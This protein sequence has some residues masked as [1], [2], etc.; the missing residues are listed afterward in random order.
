M[1]QRLVSAINEVKGKEDILAELLPMFSIGDSPASISTV[2]G[3]AEA[4]AL[5]AFDVL[6]EPD[7]DK[8]IEAFSKT[9]VLK[10]RTPQVRLVTVSTKILRAKN[11]H[12]SNEEEF[13]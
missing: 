2:P 5:V 12:I 4:T 6:N 10:T 8:V 3:P 11:V 1:L 7:L 13:V 9:A